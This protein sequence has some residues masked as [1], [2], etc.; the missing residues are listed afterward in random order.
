MKKRITALL[1]AAVLLLGLAACGGQ[2]PTEDPSNAQTTAATDDGS[3]KT[4]ITLPYMSADVLNPFKTQSHVNKDIAD[5]LFDSLFQIDD[6]FEAV[7][8]LAVEATPQGDTL[9]VTLREDVRFSSGE[10]LTAR[11]V[12]YSFQLAKESPLFAPRLG[13]VFSAAADADHLVRF[14]L[15][16]PDVFAV[17]CLDFPVVQFS[18]GEEEMPVG[19]GRFLYNASKEGSVRLLRNENTASFDE[20]AFD[21][22]AL[23]DISQ[24]VNALPLV[25]IGQLT[26]YLL[27]PSRRSA[28]KVGG[29]MELVH[30]NNLVFCGFNSESEALQEKAVRQAISYAVNK[31][32]LVSRAYA[33]VA[34]PTQTPFH[35]LWSALDA[36]MQTPI[37]DTERANELLEEAGYVYEGGTKVRSKEG[38][39]LSL[40][41]LVNSENK[42]RLA[43]AK[44]LQEMLSV[45]GFGVALESIDYNSYVARLKSGGF[46]LYLGEVKLPADMSLSAFFGEEGSA[47]YG[48]DLSGSVCT[49]YNELRAGRT[50]MATFVKVFVQELPFLPLC[51]RDACLYYTGELNY[52][53][54]VSENALYSN[55][56]TWS[57][58]GN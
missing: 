38:E 30:M 27:D 47:N 14:T 24:T 29:S 21:E 55:I 48:I 35:P 16:A 33:D 4:V 45:V 39:P 50:E 2:Q 54:S 23:Y 12:V 15:L 3:K 56:Y 26:C 25:E 31:S 32:V 51:F 41:L 40:R 7:P 5:L 43:A 53:G 6:A 8:V 22:I 37:F 28:E 1:C 9:M 34:Q 58:K 13:N 42:P 10:L 11:D 17:N 49:G 20:V 44:S 57:L 46:D 36:N 19:T 52:E 18:T